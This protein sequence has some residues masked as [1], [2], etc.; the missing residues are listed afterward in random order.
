MVWLRPDS[1]QSSEEECTLK[2]VS[3]DD[4]TVEYRMLLGLCGAG[5]PSTYQALL[6]LIT[7]RSPFFDRFRNNLPS[8]SPAYAT[9]GVLGGQILQCRYLSS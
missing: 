1:T 6:D 9:N 7:T 2:H 5:K 3:L 4:Y 8:G